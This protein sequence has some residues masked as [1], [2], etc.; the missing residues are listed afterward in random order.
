MGVRNYLIVGMDYVRTEMERMGRSRDRCQPLSPDR[1][2]ASSHNCP[3]PCFAVRSKPGR[4]C[5]KPSATDGLKQNWQEVGINR[6]NKS[7]LL[8]QVSLHLVGLNLLKS[9][10]SAECGW[11]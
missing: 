3:S 2:Q 9:C 6:H 5:A 11:S 1:V 4:G 10:D 7:E 8:L